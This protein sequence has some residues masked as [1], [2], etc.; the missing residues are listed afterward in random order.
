MI[1]HRFEFSITAVAKTASIVGLTAFV[2]SSIEFYEI[3]LMSIWR[4]ITQ[5]MV[6][7]SKANV[8][9]EAISHKFFA[10]ADITNAIIH[11]SIYYLLTLMMTIALMRLRF[12]SIMLIMLQVLFNYL[13]WVPGYSFRVNIL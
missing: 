13:P 5:W 6:Q 9:H 7:W 11:P 1:L 3:T 12:I 2:S 8:K 10:A 4:I